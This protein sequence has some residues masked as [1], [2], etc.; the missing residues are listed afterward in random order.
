MTGWR[1]S[2]EIYTH[3]QHSGPTVLF[4]GTA[5][6][7]QGLAPGAWH[8]IDLKP[9][10]V[11]ADAVFAELNGFLIITHSGPTA[12]ADLIVCVRPVGSS[13][14]AGNYQMQVLERWQAGGQRAVQPVTVSLNDGKFE[15]Q[16]MPRVAGQ[17]D[18]GAG[19][20][21]YLVNLWLA[22]WG[23]YEPVTSAPPPPPDPAE[24]LVVVVPAAGRVIHLVHS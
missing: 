20:N 1:K 17:Y 12:D 9:L 11:A 5:S 2:N 15:L 3:S 23:R 21:A 18:G 6:G 24:P 7:Q 16:W 14:A 13:L 4:T 22:K 10:G 8:T 19:G